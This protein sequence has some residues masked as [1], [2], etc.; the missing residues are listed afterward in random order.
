MA[1]DILDEILELDFTTAIKKPYP[2]HCF[3]P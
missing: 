3:S 2:D 1:I